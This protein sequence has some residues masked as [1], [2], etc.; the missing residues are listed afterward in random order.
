M[1]VADCADPR[2]LSTVDDCSICGTGVWRSEHTILIAHSVSVCWQCAQKEAERGQ[3]DVI[4]MTDAT[5]AALIADGLSIAQ[6]E[7]LDE[8]AAAILNHPSAARRHASLDWHPSF[9][10]ARRINHG[11]PR[12]DDRP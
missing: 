8:R 7:R 6:T 2:Y 12:R 4:P 1:R 3:L 5:R 10:S 11:N 9:G